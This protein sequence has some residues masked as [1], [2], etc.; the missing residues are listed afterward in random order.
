MPMMMIYMLVLKVVQLLVL[1]LVLQ[2]V[3]C[4]WV[5]GID[6]LL[7]LL[8]VLLR[9][10]KDRLLGHNKQEQLLPIMILHGKQTEMQLPGIINL[11]PM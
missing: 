11:L 7:P 2:S 1:P 4:R 8:L 3:V 9:T 5:I 10:W 6:P